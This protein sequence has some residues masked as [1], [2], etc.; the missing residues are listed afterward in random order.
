MAYEKIALLEVVLFNPKVFGDER[1]FLFE[2]FSEH[3]FLE[4]TGLD[5]WFVQD[6]HRKLV[7]GVL[8]GAVALPGAATCPRQAGAGC[9]V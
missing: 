6:N 9:S 1:S 8:R 2:S 4:P 3:D 5:N 7:R